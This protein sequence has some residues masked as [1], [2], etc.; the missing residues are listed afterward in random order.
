[1]RPVVTR[2]NHPDAENRI[3]ASGPAH[4]RPDLKLPSVWGL[5]PGSCVS[6]PG[7]FQKFR[8]EFL[9]AIRI[10]TEQRAEQVRVRSAVLVLRIEQVSGQ[11]AIIDDCSISM[12]QLH[13]VA[14]S[15]SIVAGGLELMS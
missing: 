8:S 5:L 3:L 15:H 12:R 10:N 6:T 13:L 1:M 2:A 7:C 11:F 14:Y 9:A 4:L